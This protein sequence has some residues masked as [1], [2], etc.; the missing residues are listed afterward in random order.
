MA[1][2]VEKQVSLFLEKA[3][4]SQQNSK[5]LS[6]A[7]LRMPNKNRFFNNSQYKEE[8]GKSSIA[9]LRYEQRK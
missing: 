4:V 3:P 9:Q 2:G 1:N 5:S 6:Q 8:G 7:A